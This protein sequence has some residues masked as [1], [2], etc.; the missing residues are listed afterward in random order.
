MAAGE[1]TP[2]AAARELGVNVKTVYALCD[3]GKLEHRVTRGPVRRRIYI[4]KA[5][6]RR[7]KAAQKSGRN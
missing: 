1:L 2:R 3:D 7:M 4:P 5:E 6:I